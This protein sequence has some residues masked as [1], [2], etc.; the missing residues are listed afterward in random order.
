[1]QFLSVGRCWVTTEDRP[2][3]AEK[4]HLTKRCSRPKLLGWLRLGLPHIGKDPA[5]HHYASL[6]RPRAL[7]A[8]AFPTASRSSGNASRALWRCH[9]EASEVLEPLRVP[10]SLAAAGDG[11]PA[12][13]PRKKILLPG[14]LGGDQG[15]GCCCGRRG[16]CASLVVCPGCSW[17]A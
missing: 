13:T 3:N 17:G 2:L 5:W 8:R 6:R 15:G 7:P 9:G 1:M 12:A 14:V 16:S 11:D 4:C 10:R